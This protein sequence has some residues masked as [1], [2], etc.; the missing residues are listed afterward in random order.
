MSTMLAAPVLV[1]N[2]N[3]EPLNVCTTRRAIGLMM[4]EKAILVQNGRG[5]I[6][7]VRQKFPAPNIIRLSYIIKRPRPVVKLSKS[8]VFRR[9]KYIC[10]YCGKKSPNLT[11]DHVIPRSKAGKHSW[12]NLVTACAKCNNRKGNRT[13]E[14]ANMKLLTAPKAP[15]ASALYIFGKFTNNN[16]EWIPF[17]KGW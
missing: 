15:G 8:E 11:I 4:S 10:Q 7:G 5:Y 12:G 17:I 14:Q 16:K 1:L 13:D 9:D 3:F 6:Q 2:A